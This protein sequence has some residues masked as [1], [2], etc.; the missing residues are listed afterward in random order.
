MIHVFINRYINYFWEEIIQIEAKMNVMNDKHLIKYHTGIKLEEQ[1]HFVHHP[2]RCFP[3]Q[4]DSQH[5]ENN[6]IGRFRT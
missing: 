5:K 3:N 4:S 6:Y 2:S 1:L